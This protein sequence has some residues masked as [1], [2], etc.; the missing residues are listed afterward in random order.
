MRLRSLT[1]P[2]LPATEV[3]LVEQQ[4]RWTATTSSISLAGTWS[5][6]AIVRAGSDATQV[7]LV[8]DT[9]AEGATQSADIGPGLPTITTTTFGDG[10]SLQTYVDPAEPG[11]NQIHATA[12]DV[13]GAELPVEDLAIVAIADGGEARRLDVMQLSPGHG[14][15]NAELTAGEWTFDAV[16]TTSDGAVLQATWDTSIEEATP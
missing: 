11:T 5:I 10:T 3:D 14:A 9:R 1:H 8:L 2:D 7:P 4:G 6:T 13:E 16:A 12:F 15:A